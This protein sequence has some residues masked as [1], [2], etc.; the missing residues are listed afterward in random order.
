MA[1]P[2]AASA[3]ATVRINSAKTWPVRSP[4]K[5]EKATRLILTE[6]RMSSTDIKTTMMFLRFRIIPAMPRVNI[7]AATTKNCESPIVTVSLVVRRARVAPPRS[8]SLPRSDLAELD[9]FG[10]WP[11]VLPCDVLALHLSLVAQ[12]QNNCTDHRGKKHQ[13]RGLEQI[14]VLR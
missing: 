2:I 14:S 6:S 10:R 4:K 12:S 1:S 5:A 13:S 7:I 3:A 8:N 9:G 11:R